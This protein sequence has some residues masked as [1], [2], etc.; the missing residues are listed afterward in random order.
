MDVWEIRLRNSIGF[1]KEG[2]KTEPYYV[3]DLIRDLMDTCILL[4][5]YTIEETES[6]AV[7]T[8]DKET[9]LVC[10]YDLGKVKKRAKELIERF[11][12][13]HRGKAVGADAFRITEEQ[14]YIE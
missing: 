2:D 11:K 13:K 3:D 1:M 12:R 8:G 5:L 9:Y 6:G 7:F 14:I 4:E 10:G